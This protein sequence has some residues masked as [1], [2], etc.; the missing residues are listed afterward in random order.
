[1]EHATSEVV[2]FEREFHDALDEAATSFD[3]A[4]IERV[5][6]RWWRVA[7]VRSIKLSGT[8]EQQVRRAKAGDF[9]GLWE[10]ADDGT[11]RRIE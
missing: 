11:F 2:V 1:M 5:L 6:D 3:T 7:V 9:G 4:A 10:R 8:E